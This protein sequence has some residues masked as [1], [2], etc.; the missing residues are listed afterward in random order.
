MNPRIPSITLL[1]D[2]PL[3]G[4][5]ALACVVGST[6]CGDGSAPTPTEAVQQRQGFVTPLLDDNGQA[7]SVTPDAR[8]ADAAAWT[9]NGR[10]ATRAQAEQLLN[11]RG[12]G[13]LQVQVGCCGHEAIDTA[14]GVAWGLQA[15]QQ[16]SNQTP[17][18]V[19]GE[20]L[21]LAAATANRLLEGGLVNVWLVTPGR[22][23]PAPR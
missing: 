13:V 23:T 4:A 22:Q 2:R 17:V 1:V 21:R 12:D 16:L 7:Q 5:L 20:D 8:P 14:A 9:R 11:A 15:A 10:Y 19:Q 3:L 18:L 6:G